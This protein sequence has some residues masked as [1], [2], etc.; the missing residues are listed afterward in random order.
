[1]VRD[2]PEGAAALVHLVEVMGATITVCSRPMTSWRDKRQG[3][4]LSEGCWHGKIIYSAV[5]ILES[6]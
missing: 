5:F 4:L 3:P 6:L 2:L 1:M